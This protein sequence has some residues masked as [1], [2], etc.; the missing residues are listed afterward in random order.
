M[1]TLLAIAVGVLFAGA[2]YMLLRRSLVKILIGLT[3]L[4][5]AANLLIF[6]ASGVT[7]SQPPILPKTSGSMTS[8]LADPLPQALVLTA[9]VI[10]FGIQ[11]FA[12]ALAYRSY[13]TSGTDDIE[14]LNNTDHMD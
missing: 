8:S 12:L 1:N 11:A 9:I 4:T 7:R 14:E 13:K 6:S 3:L 10:G 2:V 5:H